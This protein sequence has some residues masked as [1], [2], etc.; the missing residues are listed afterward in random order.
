[1]LLPVGRAGG[2]DE[3][4]GLPEEGARARGGDF[5]GGLAAA[6]HGPRVSGL[7]GLDRQRRRI[8]P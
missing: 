5:T 2:A 6:H 7:A 3:F 8:R 4:G 1:M